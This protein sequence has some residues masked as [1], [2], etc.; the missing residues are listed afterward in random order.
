MNR[1][2]TFYQKYGVMERLSGDIYT[3]NEPP[4]SV[5]LER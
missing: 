1:L 3:I 5:E 4:K 2:D